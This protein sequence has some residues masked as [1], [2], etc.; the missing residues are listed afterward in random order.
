MGTTAKREICTC[1]IATGESVLQE[2]MREI[3][4]MVNMAEIYQGIIITLA[5][6]ILIFIARQI[7][8]TINSKLDLIDGISQATFAMNKDKLFRFCRFY[9][10]TK[11]ITLEEK[12]ELRPIYDAY[13]AQGG[14]HVGDDLFRQVM[15][16]PVVEKRTVYN[17]YYANR[18]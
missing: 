3:I 2:D 6:A 11:Q 15:A 16:L 10:S 13:K 5:S 8:A 1:K 9:I 7:Y 18:E 17:P 4:P 12:E 14:N